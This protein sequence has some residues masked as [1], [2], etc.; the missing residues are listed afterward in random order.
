MQL[1]PIRT[2]TTRKSI[3]VADKKTNLERIMKYT[4]A[5]HGPDER[6]LGTLE[7]DVRNGSAEL[8]ANL[9]F[10]KITWV[11]LLKEWATP[12]LLLALLFKR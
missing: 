7:C 12:V 3:K 8:R 5:L 10:P 9:E 2:S 1:A 6:I 4:A 11:D